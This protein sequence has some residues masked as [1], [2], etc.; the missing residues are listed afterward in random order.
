MKKLTVLCIFAAVIMPF[1]SFDAFG[2][3]DETTRDHV[4]LETFTAGGSKVTVVE[5]TDNA[6]GK[7]FIEAT[8]V[9]TNKVRV[10]VKTV[11]EIIEVPLETTPHKARLAVMP[12]VFSEHFH[13]EFKFSEKIEL[14]GQSALKMIFTTEHESR[15]EAPS[16]TLSLN[17]T[18]VNS[19]KFDVLERGRLNETLK[20]IDFGES[21]YANAAKVVPMGQALNAEYV[22][23]PE[24]D[25]VHLVLEVRDIPYVDR[26]QPRLK[27]KMIVRMRVVDTA[28]TKTVAACTE[29]V[30]VERRIK[31]DDPFW[32]S[33]MNNLV[34]DLYSTAA[35]RLLNR[36]L[37]AVYP[38]RMLELNKDRVVLNRGHGAIDVGD[39]FE[40]FT[41]GKAYVD[42]D[43]GE[44]LGRRETK[45][46]SI[47]VHR[48]AP[49][50][51]EAEILQGRDA[52]TDEPGA[53]VC[54]ETAD[55]I[56]SKT[57]IKQSPMAW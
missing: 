31:D 29:E 7:E 27:G 30:E 57:T 9:T 17:E 21:D 37:E 24:I 23:L 34:L 56:K 41:L 14:S 46:A 35:L 49:K 19:R 55:S 48:V 2:D 11:K 38:V 52:L 47:R 45:V 20:E 8:H 25:V 33:E 15:M 26:V 36:T 44:M 18:F 50:F 6:S 51:S 42:P 12:A 28:S 39:E 43:T 22:A 5:A 32:A 1:T 4:K 16:F 10:P 40:I 53:Y 3:D 13:P 54:R